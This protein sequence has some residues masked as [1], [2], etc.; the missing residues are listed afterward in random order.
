MSLCSPW[1]K[2]FQSTYHGKKCS[3]LPTVVTK[4]KKTWQ[5]FWQTLLL[6]SLSPGQ[7]P[8]TI[9]GGN[10]DNM[11]KMSNWKWRGQGS[12]DIP[13]SSRRIWEWFILIYT[14]Q[15]NISISSSKWGK[16]ATRHNL[17]RV[18]QISVALERFIKSDIY[19]PDLKIVICQ[20]SLVNH[21]LFHTCGIPLISVYINI[22]YAHTC[23][24][25]NTYADVCIF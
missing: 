4:V 19:N 24:C 14:K 2:C 13:N 25:V 15:S 21:A 20:L 6:L 3:S 7:P 1:W 9:P 11:Y 16:M 22:S 17:V 5:N 12:V 23:P 10:Q 8:A 18:P